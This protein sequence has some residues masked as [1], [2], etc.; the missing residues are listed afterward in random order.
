MILK[1][2]IILKIKKILLTLGNV[3]NLCE[4]HCLSLNKIFSL[5]LVD[6]G[7]FYMRR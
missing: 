4:A 1:K 3:R 6:T 5:A 7:R 2:C